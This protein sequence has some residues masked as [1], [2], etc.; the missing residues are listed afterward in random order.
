MTATKQ[1]IE[2]GDWQTPLDLAQQVCER[3]AR[4]GV[5]PD[6][7]VE[8][9]CGLG[10]FVVAAAGTFSNAK[11]IHGFEI[12]PA[13]VDHLSG[14]LQHVPHHER[15]TLAVDDFFAKDW[16]AVLHK[17]TGELLVIGNPPWVTS[18][19]LGAIGGH[20]L[21]GKSNFQSHSGFDAMTGK[22]NFDISEHMMMEMLRWFR[23][24]KGTLAMLCKTAVARKVLAHAQRQRA[25]VAEASIMLVDTK[26]HFNAAVDSCLLVMRFAVSIDRPDLTYMVYPDLDTLEGYRV[27]HRAGLL[28]RN[29]ETFDRST[30]F[31]GRSPQKWRSGIKHDASAI[32]EFAR[33]DG[34]LFN[35]AG[36]AV[37][38]EPDYLYPLMK[39]S[40]VANG[41]RVWR[42]RFV[43]VTQRAIGEPTEAIRHQAPRTWAYLESKRSELDARSSRIYQNAPLFAIFGVG[44]YS[45]RPWRIAICGL[46]KSLRFRLVGP[47][48]SKPVMFD[49]T[50]YF[51][52]F[53]SEAEARR[54]HAL[55]TSPAAT[56]LLDSLI[57][58]D[59]KRPIKTSVLNLL[60]WSK[61]ERPM[62]LF[63]EVGR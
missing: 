26:K 14:Q 38:L 7:I 2:F 50:V 3:L 23:G 15:I 56:E 47:M 25:Q 11:H 13:Y 41:E 28:V 10:A 6:V 43:L 49:D 19:G 63:A 55:I 8:P 60:D 40:D 34:Q 5:D 31:L 35:G 61:S 4:M 45:F 18:A 29:T 54:V 12:N 42:E 44:D 52:A 24:R 58:W 51:V 53:D 16:K 57:F 27:G 62:G 22:A 37:D 59:E 36:E 48:D 32:M 39:G 1:R 46:Y 17:L 20:N 33:K 30:H 21:P 9:T